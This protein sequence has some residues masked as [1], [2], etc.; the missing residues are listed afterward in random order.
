MLEA[1]VGSLAL[2]AISLWLTISNRP[3]N[4]NWPG[5]AASRFAAGLI[6]LGYAVNSLIHLWI[7]P[8]PDSL[9]LMQQ[10][11]LYAALPIVVSSHL[12]ERL[13][14]HWSRQ[15]WGRIFLGWC[16]VFELARRNNGLELVLLISIGLG[17]FAL[18]LAIVTLPGLSTNRDALADMSNREKLWQMGIPLI[19]L[20]GLFVDAQH[21]LTDVRAPLWLATALAMFCLAQ[22]VSYRMAS[23]NDDDSES[24][25]DTTQAGQD[26]H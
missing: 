12:A 9:L 18:W 14:K 13:Q 5:S 15:I 6:C 26:N 2:L 4:G 7:Q 17:L 10:L 16:V 1:Q 8:L 24:A 19:A 3:G 20:V 21:T 23:V 11:S 25:N 22:P